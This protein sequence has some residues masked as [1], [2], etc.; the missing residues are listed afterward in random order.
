VVPDDLHNAGKAVGRACEVGDLVEY[1]GQRLV[2][3]QGGEE[4]QRRLPGGESAAR[5]VDTV[6]AKI[7]AYGLS[8]PGQLDRLGLLGRAEEHRALIANELGE[9]VGLAHPAT[10]PD[11]G[12]LGTA[13]AGIRPGVFERLEL[14][15]SVDQASFHGSIVL[16]IIRSIL[17]IN[18]PGP[19]RSLQG[20]GWGWGRG[21]F[22]LGRGLA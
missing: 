13:G 9:K 14:G 18:C 19:E 15:A 8:Q 7:A 20:T 4:P 10:P 11:D 16:Q 22:V 17:S 5:E 1:H 6:V 2:H 3:G 12:K 21:G